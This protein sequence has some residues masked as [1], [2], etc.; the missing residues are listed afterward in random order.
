[1]DFYKHLVSANGA[2]IPGILRDGQF[3]TESPIQSYLIFRTSDIKP[4]ETKQFVNE[5]PCIIKSIFINDDAPN[6][7]D[8]NI[9]NIHITPPPSSASRVW[10]VGFGNLEHDSE[11]PGITSFGDTKVINFPFTL[12]DKGAIFSIGA[13]RA[14]NHVELA[15]RQSN[16]KQLQD[17][18]FS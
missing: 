4:R 1:M 14:I 16:L 6:F 3:I 5:H 15:G 2:S 9:Y 11:T 7:P 8:N 12:L 17:K 18:G 13:V 10:R